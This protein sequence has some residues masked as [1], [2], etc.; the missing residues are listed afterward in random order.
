MSK[1]ICDTLRFMD[2]YQKG[3]NGKQVAYATRKYRG[4]RT[5]LLSIFGGL[6]KAKMPAIRLSL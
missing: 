4:H 6:E 5:L 2:A 3:L 1:Q